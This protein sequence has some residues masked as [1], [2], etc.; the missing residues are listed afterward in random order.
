MAQILLCEDDKLIARIIGKILDNQKHQIKI[1]SNGTEAIEEL[2]KDHY[3]LVITDMIMPGF[4]G[5][6]IVRFIRRQL[7]S[8]CPILL[9]SGLS[10]KEFIRKAKK[11]G[12]TDFISKPVNID[13]LKRKV[14]H[15]ISY[16]EEIEI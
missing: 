12:T 16:S 13:I 8:R 5:L 14:A 10:D 4:S 15:L 7:R 9:M 2:K 1:V 6:D 3:D 11:V